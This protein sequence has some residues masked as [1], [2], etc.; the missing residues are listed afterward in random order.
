MIY[1]L[2]E[3]LYRLFKFLGIGLILYRID[4]KKNIIPFDKSEYFKFVESNQDID[5]Y[6]SSLKHVTPQNDVPDTDVYKE[7]RF[8]S[9]IHLVKLALGSN[10]E[11]EVAE[12]G[13]Y[14]GHS[15]FIISKFI[16]EITPEKKFFIFDSFAGLSAKDPDLDRPAFQS[17]DE[18]IVTDLGRFSCSLKEVQKNLAEF[19]FIRYFKGYIPER[20]AEVT[21]HRF[22]FVHIDVDLYQPTFDA[23]DFFYPKLVKGGIIIIDDYGSSLYKGAARAVDN[24]LKNNTPSVF[25]E[26]PMGSAFIIK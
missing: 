6:F 15:S 5:L 1:K 8:L 16:K 25:Y 22:C 26:V 10:L 20:F 24:Y 3:F 13:C 2:R 14:R 19:L 12:C 7:L 21:D 23:L 9:L 11:G 18:E 4:S 17:Q